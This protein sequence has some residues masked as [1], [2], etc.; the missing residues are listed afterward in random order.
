MPE[1][2]T[3]YGFSAA[4]RPATFRQRELIRTAAE[5]SAGRAQVTIR[6]RIWL[7]E[8]AMILLQKILVATD[9]GPTSVAALEYARG[10]ARKFGATL[11][12]MHVAENSFLRPTAADPQAFREAA[13]NSLSESLTDEDRDQLHARPILEVSDEP[14]ETIVACAKS[15]GVDLIVMGTHG[16][17]AISQLL[18]GSVAERVVRTAGCPVL[19]VRTAAGEG[20]AN[21]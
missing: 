13:W 5:N 14:S 17:N 21:H 16:R 18:I 8:D 2:R 15:E 12:V 4:I 6:R 10:L 19:T 3:F 11:Y 9:F 1:F 7:Y 20:P